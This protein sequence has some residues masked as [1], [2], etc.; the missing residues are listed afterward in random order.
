[1]K[2]KENIPP[3]NFAVGVNQQIVIKDVGTV[4][5]ESNEMVT[6][7]TESGKEYDIVKKEWGFYAT[8][9]LNGRLIA[10]GFKT[11]LV[12]NSFGKYYIM[13]V[14]KEKITGF[15]QYL[16]IENNFLTCWLDEKE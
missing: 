2:I 12:K 8:P 10:Q 14:E 15:Q 3:R 5:L 13:L 9:S 16:E 4:E 1:M 6:L 11:A 7:L